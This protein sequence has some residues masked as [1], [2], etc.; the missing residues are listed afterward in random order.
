MRV[1]LAIPV[2]MLL[3]CRTPSAHATQTNAVMR[4]CANCTATQMQ[5]MAKNQPVGYHFTYDLSHNIIRKYEVYMDSDCRPEAPGIRHS[6]NG[7]DGGST[8][9][10]NE[11]DCGSF[12]AADAVTP[13]NPGV[14]AIFN[15]L[16]A[17]WLANPTLV[18]TG[19]AIVLNPPMNPNKGRPFD[20]PK[21]GWEYD[22]GEYEDMREYLRDS[23]LS[24]RGAANAFAPGLGD[25]IFGVSLAVDGVDIGRPPDI[26][27]VHITLD[28]NTGT[29]NIEICNADLDC[30]KWTVTIINGSVTNLVFNGAYD[31]RNMQYPAENGSNPGNHNS[32]HWTNGSDADHF[33]QQVH[34]N[35]GVTVPIRQGC[36]SS[37]HPGLL[38]A[39]VNG[40]VDSMTWQCLAN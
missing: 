7:G 9:S 4:E 25:Y 1:L 26:I 33:A 23:V 6:A 29:V 5:T 18:N 16:R 40:V 13:V 3:T 31:K 38:V 21:T 17:A 36:G 35:S 12:K 8:D 39:R 32:W 20:I 2:A 15:S 27:R 10:G 14:Q 11:T 22:Q 19:K 37:F 28:H 34:N 30:A 24:S